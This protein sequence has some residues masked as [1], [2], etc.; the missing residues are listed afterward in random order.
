M[1]GRLAL[2]LNI[3]APRPQGPPF[4][5]PIPCPPSVTLAHRAKGVCPLN[6]SSIPQEAENP[7]GYENIPKLLRGFAIPSIV[8]ML[9]SSL[10][11]IVDQVFIGWGVGYL[12]NAATNVAYPLTTI[13][14]AIA[15][16]IS[17]GSASRFSLYL[18]R[19]EG[20][21][22]ASIAGNAISMAL[23]FGL[24]YALLIEI[25][26]DPLLGLFGSTPEVFPYA[27]EYARITALG[28]PFFILTKVLSTLARA[29][30]SPRYSMLCITA[31]AV[32][33]TI[34]DPIFIFVLGMGVRGAAIATVLGQVFS[35]LLAAV[36]LWR[37]RSIRLERKHFAIT[38]Y[39]SITIVTYG[40]SNSFNQVAIT[41]VQIVLNNSLVYYGALSPYGR[42][43][44]LAASGIVM[45]TNAILLAI[46]IG[47]SQG[48]QPIIG[49]NYGAGKADR[50]KQAFRILIFS[51]L[52]YAGCM[53]GLIMA[54]PQVF[55]GL[56]NS[57]AEL[58]EITVWALRIYL[59]CFFL[60]G[61]Q[62][63]CQQTFVALGQ[64]KVSL[65]LALLRKVI[66]LIPLIFILPQFVGDK[67]FAVFL[68]EP[69]ADFLAAAVTGTVFFVRFPKILKAKVGQSA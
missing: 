14:L 19:G 22:A 13:C 60:L 41:L 49:F 10:Y 28:L 24:L 40:M 57:K 58:V 38:L 33:N 46:I 52:V 8:A 3:L 7:L 34:L 5:H 9:V 39:E 65:F 12:G 43:I 42:E 1:P 32:L 23:V 35:F 15:L 62:F 66:L 11:N 17:A 69:A 67:V 55:V 61:I 50:V 44:P 18:G 16:L 63:S 26:L 59:A 56:F 29:D 6:Q 64:A 51:S 21:R 45:K 20:E 31:G 25:F 47:I 30:G 2:L 68:A 36:Y 4:S 53:W 48:T 27:Q 37:F 54:L